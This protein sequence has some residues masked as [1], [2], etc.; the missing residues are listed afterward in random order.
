MLEFW[1]ELLL[2]IAGEIWVDMIQGVKGLFTGLGITTIRASFTVAGKVAESYI[3]AYK[4]FN[5]GAR[6][7]LNWLWNSKGSSSNPG[8]LKGGRCAIV[9][10]ILSMVFGAF[11]RLT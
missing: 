8:A 4:S 3:W 5:L 7:S 9:Y 6:T 11:S 2:P 10:S 1:Q